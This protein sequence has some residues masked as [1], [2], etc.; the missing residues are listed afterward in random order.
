MTSFPFTIITNDEI[1][2]EKLRELKDYFDALM[3]KG[4]LSP[5]YE[6][7]AAMLNGI[8]HL[9]FHGDVLYGRKTPPPPIYRITDEY[10]DSK[11]FMETEM[12]RIFAEIMYYFADKYELPKEQLGGWNLLT[13][14][15]KEAE[16]KRLSGQ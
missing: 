13:E 5:G 2:K 3:R 11:A 12:G 10:I 9:V 14:E 15:E 4:L 6:D 16:M 8:Y 7:I 1:F